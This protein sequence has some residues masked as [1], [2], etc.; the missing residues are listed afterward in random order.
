MEKHHDLATMRANYK[1]AALRKEKLYVLLD[2][3]ETQELSEEE[4]HLYR[5]PAP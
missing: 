1:Q 5:L 4:H 2:M 3:L